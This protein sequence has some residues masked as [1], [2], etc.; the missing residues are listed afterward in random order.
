MERKQVKLFFFLLIILFATFGATVDT[1]FNNPAFKARLVGGKELPPVQTKAHGE[2]TLQLNNGR[3]KLTYNVII[4]NIKDI[5]GAYIHQGKK[6]QQSGPTVVDLFNEPKREDISGT[7]LADG[8][9]EADMLIGPLKGK[10][11]DS[12]IQLMEA[13]EAYINVYTKDHPQGEIRGQIE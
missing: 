4:S 13:G 3:D 10:S 9:I 1:S 11:L 5:T 8:V 12:L 6:D 2:V 7:F